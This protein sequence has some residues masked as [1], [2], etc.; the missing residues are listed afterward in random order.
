M[1]NIST[2]AR[3]NETIINVNNVDKNRTPQLRIYC[4]ILDPILLFG[5]NMQNALVLFVMCIIARFLSQPVTDNR[6]KIKMAVR[7]WD[8]LDVCL[9][10][11]HCLSMLGYM[12]W[13]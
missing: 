1:L 8:S 3:Q 10:K 13:R 12:M 6:L 7:N 2:S 4:C 11:V 9:Y 5:R